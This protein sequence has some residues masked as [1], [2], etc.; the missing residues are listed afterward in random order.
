MP[1]AE[2]EGQARRLC[3]PGHR[4]ASIITFLGTMLDAVALGSSPY[5]PSLQAV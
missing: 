3:G 5:K 2:T 4:F 1:K